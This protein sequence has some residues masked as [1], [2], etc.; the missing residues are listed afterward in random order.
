M[1]AY[2]L[3]QRLYATPVDRVNRLYQSFINYIRDTLE[4]RIQNKIIP[5]YKPLEKKLEDGESLEDKVITGAIKYKDGSVE[6][7]SSRQDIYNDIQK[8]STVEQ[9]YKSFINSEVGRKLTEYLAKKGYP[10]HDQVDGYGFLDL[11]KNAIAAVIDTGKQKILSLSK[12]YY[13][14][15][16]HYLDKLYVMAHEYIHTKGE[17]SEEKTEGLLKEFFREMYQK[18]RDSDYNKLAKVAEAREAA[19]AGK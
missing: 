11:G 13:N 4:Y 18:T 12:R 19:Q 15:L 9:L 10:T 6:A 1:T 3:A 17:T 7:V 2:S 8:T 14:K 5:T 16:N